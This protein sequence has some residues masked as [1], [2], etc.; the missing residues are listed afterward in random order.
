ML[1]LEPVS[2][3]N[4]WQ[5]LKLRVHEEQ[6][7]FVAS[8]TESLVE[9]YLALSSGG[10]AWPFGIYDGDTPVGF[11]MVGY[12][13]DEEWENPPAYAREGYTLWRLMIDRQYQGRGYGRAAIGL[14]LDFIHTF[15]CGPSKTCYLSYEPANAR[16]RALYLSMGFAETGDMDGDETVAIMAP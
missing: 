11:L 15:P 3:K 16:A 14:A 8:N 4:V 13:A 6:K 5:L 2:R 1:R 12:G 7:D 10:H 9:A